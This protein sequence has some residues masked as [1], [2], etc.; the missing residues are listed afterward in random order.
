MLMR[1]YTRQ[2]P[3]YG[4]IDLHAR[5]MH[6]CVLDAAGNVRLDQNLLCHFKTL[7]QA[8][9]P[10]HDGIVLGVECMFGW[11]WLADRCAEP[12][13][14]FVVGHAGCRSGRGGCGR[15]RRCRAERTISSAAAHVP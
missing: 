9:A 2:H 10:F 5:T 15:G 1:F 11:Y 3:F 6:V 7:L 14:P 13:I 12:A 4:G 8:T